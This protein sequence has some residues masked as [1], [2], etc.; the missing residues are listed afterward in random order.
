MKYLAILI[1]T[2]FVISCEEEVAKN[3]PIETKIT[4]LSSNEYFLGDTISIEGE[5]FGTLSSDVMLFFVGNS[6]TIFITPYYKNIT[7]WSPT[8]IK[9]INDL[10]FEANFVYVGFNGKPY[11]SIPI[12]N[13]LYPKVEVVEI[14]SGTYLQ[15]NAD[16]FS[17]ERITRNVTISK[18]LLVA[19]YELSQRLW[20]FVYN[21]N[22]SPRV[23]D[24][25]PISNVTWNEA[26]L[27]CNEL[28]KMYGL[29]TCYIKEDNQYNFNLV[30]K[31]WRLPTEAEWEYLANIS[32]VEATQ[33]SQF[34]WYN[35][36]SGYNA[37]ILGT[38]RIDQAGLY[39]LFGNVWEWCYDD[40]T[41]EYASD[42]TI[43]PINIKSNSRKVRRGGSY[44]SGELYCRKT[45]RT[46][47]NKSIVSTGIRLVRN[48]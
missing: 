29:D 5:D 7:E 31:G 14:A 1:M 8:K 24:N 33:L 4:K 22:N 10:D 47:A 17:D 27:Y 32:N 34:A 30:A 43:D 2:F 46:T 41:S 45:N 15:G 19:R 36:N 48:K 42:D 6:D 44:Q 37:K 3:D 20:A 40:Y 23:N 11:D 18:T 26:I 38:K 9:F 39:D 13:Y 16:G 21:Y 28:S 12:K 35:D 25:L